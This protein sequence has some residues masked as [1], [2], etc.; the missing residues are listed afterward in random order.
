LQGEKKKRKKEKE[1]RKGKRARKKI[2]LEYEFSQ[3]SNFGKFVFV[4]LITAT[5]DDYFIPYK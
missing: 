1:K 4:L 5:E 2:T 3:L